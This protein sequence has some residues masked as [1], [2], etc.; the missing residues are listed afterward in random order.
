VLKN[1]RG[2]KRKEMDILEQEW[3][4]MLRLTSEGI[5][6]KLDSARWFVDIDKDVSA[7]LYTYALE[8]FGK[9]ILLSSCKRVANNTKRKVM[10]AEEFTNH[11]KKFPA[12]FD[13]L[14]DNGYEECYVLNNEGGFS[15]E[16]FSWKGFDVGLLAD[17]EAR[18]SIFYSD[19]V[20]DANQNIVIQKPP[21][22]DLDMLGKA[23]NKLEAV[24]N[25]YPLPLLP[26]NANNGK[27]EIS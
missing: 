26:P 16:S 17:F 10:Y 21:A 11:E 22:V 23:I 9:L 18:M 19:F 20:Y 8:E 24:V 7:G 14:E 6:R 5:I 3:K 2:D 13:Y 27:P 4:Q 25:N 1:E 15:P 12:A